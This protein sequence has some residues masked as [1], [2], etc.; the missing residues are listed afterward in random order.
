MEDTFQNPSIQVRLSLV[1][2]LILI[3]LA[4][5]LKQIPRKNESNMSNFSCIQWACCFHF[6]WV[7]ASNLMLIWRGEM[8]EQT[9]IVINVVQ[10]PRVVKDY[11]TYPRIV[12]ATHSDYSAEPRVVQ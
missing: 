6:S 1:F 7:S 3:R 10:Y 2:P 11:I 12:Q 4:W 8:G 9:H 5:G